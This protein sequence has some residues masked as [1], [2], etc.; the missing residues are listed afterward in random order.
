M[1]TMRRVA[2]RVDGAVTWLTAAI[3]SPAASSASPTRPLRRQDR[4]ASTAAVRNADAD[5]PLGDDQ[6]PGR[7]GGS[8]SRRVAGPARPGRPRSASTGRRSCDRA[9]PARS[10]A[11]TS[12][13]G[14]TRSSAGRRR[15]GVGAAGPATPAHDEQRRRR[16][17]R[18]HGRKQRQLAGIVERAADRWPRRRPPWTTRMRPFRRPSTAKAD[19]RKR[20]AAS[21]ATRPRAQ[22]S[23]ATATE[24]RVAA[25]MMREVQ[26]LVDDGRHDRPGRHRQA[27][28]AVSTMP[29]AREADIAHGLGA[30][31]A[32]A[33]ASRLIGASSSSSTWSCSSAVRESAPAGR[34]TTG[35]PP[36]RSSGRP[37]RSR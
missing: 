19:P 26:P 1:V 36:D 9:R 5:E 34:T 27:V 37:P 14:T 18:E 32:V 21:P 20:A 12:A 4:C 23:A 25:V 22:L 29:R 30:P 7:A 15:S 28:K 10:R 35:G 6:R 17:A 13:A 3:S 31:R 2:A 16:P 8:G 11:P 33:P 24:T